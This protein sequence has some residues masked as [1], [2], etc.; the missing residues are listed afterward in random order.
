MKKAFTLVE[1]LVVISIIGL[2][3]SIVL[4]ALGDA[5]EN[6]RVARAIYFSSEVYHNLGSEAAGVWRF[7]DDVSDSSGMRNGG[8]NNGVT[9][10]DNSVSQINSVY[11]KTGVFSGSGNIEI[12]DNSQFSGL[13]GMDSS[14]TIDFWIN[15]DSL[16][17]YILRKLGVYEVYFSGGDIWFT[18]EYT[19]GATSWGAT[20]DMFLSLKTN[21]WQHV[22]LTVNVEKGKAIAYLN[23]DKIYTKKFSS[24]SQNFHIS[25]NNNPLFIGSMDSGGGFFSGRLDE[26]RIYNADLMIY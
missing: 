24:V 3:A 17:G 12:P 20:Y 6:A 7:S 5:R 13:D 25:D 10:A 15:P 9:F 21:K 19:D 2:L 4:F 11:G 18:F 23:G 16:D 26:V 14:I 8:V 22:A 1:L